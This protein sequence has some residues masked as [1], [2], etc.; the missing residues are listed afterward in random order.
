MEKM[1][2]KN[3]PAGLELPGRYEVLDLHPKVDELSYRPVDLR[4]LGIAE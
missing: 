3:A 2:T 4:F 1:E